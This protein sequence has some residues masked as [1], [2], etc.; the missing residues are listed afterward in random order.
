MTPCRADKAR[1]MITKKV[2]GGGGP[3]IPVGTNCVPSS[4]LNTVSEVAHKSTP[5]LP[6][7][8]LRKGGECLALGQLSE[9]PWRWTGS[10]WFSP[11]SPKE[12][13]STR[14]PEGAGGD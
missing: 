9:R 14:F 6:E 4:G 1:P 13:P 7:V 3:N 12:G 10:E 5:E 2:L 8:A 11:S